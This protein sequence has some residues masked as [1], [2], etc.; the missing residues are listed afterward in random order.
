MKRNRNTHQYRLGIW[1]SVIFL[2][3]PR[4]NPF[5]LGAEMEDSVSGMTIKPIK[6][7][8]K[9][10]KQVMQQFEKE[11]KQYRGF[12]TARASGAGVLLSPDGDVRPRRGRHSQRTRQL[13]TGNGRDGCRGRHQCL[14]E[15]RQ[16]QHQRQRGRREPRRRD[17]HHGCRS[18]YQF[19]FRK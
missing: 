1:I 19:N 12:S 10:L 18:Y 7:P 13:R 4:F 17:R 9:L 11:L 16:Q 6:K 15:R 5:R 8:K 14:P 2:S 3:H